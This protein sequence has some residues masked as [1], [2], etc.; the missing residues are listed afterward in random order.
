MSNLTEVSRFPVSPYLLQV[1][2][3]MG[4]EGGFLENGP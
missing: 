1:G 2:Y 4:V 3:S